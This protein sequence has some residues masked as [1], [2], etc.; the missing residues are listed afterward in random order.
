[1]SAGSPSLTRRSASPRVATLLLG[2]SMGFTGAS[3][4]VNEY[5]LSTT[6]TYLLGGSIEQF[7]VTIASM[8]LAMGAAGWLQRFLPDTALPEQFI[9]VE[10][11]LAVLAAFAPLACFAVFATAREHF[12][13]AQF[14][15]VIAIG[16]LVGLEIPLILRI[17]ARYANSLR[18]NLAAVLSLDYVGAFAG[19]MVWTFW[20]LRSFPITEISFL[21]AGANFAVAIVTF[22][23]FAAHGL[24]RRPRSLLALALVCAMAVGGGYLWARDWTLAIEQHLYRDPIVLSRTT[25]FQHMV[26]TEARSA[27]RT[28]ARTAP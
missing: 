5:V 9:L 16:L 27:T 20:L 10:T 13:I 6:A 1:M 17:N 25:R 24:V 22:A 2:L 14:A 11:L 19:A 15:F 4:L 28:T 3:G 8:M 7:S 26:L 21:V 23:W 18:S 12:V